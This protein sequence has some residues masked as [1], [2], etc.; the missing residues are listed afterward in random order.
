VIDFRYHV[1]SIVAI[2]LA[3]ATGIALGAGPLGKEFDQQLANQARQDREA[4]E[5]LRDQLDQTNQVMEF[6]GDFAQDLAPQLT[7]N[8]LANRTVAVFVLPGADEDTV[9]GVTSRIEGAGATIT[10]T[11]EIQDSLMDPAERQTA[12]GIATEV[13][14]GVQGLPDTEGAQ[15]YQLVGYSLARGYLATSEEG[16]PVDQVAASIDGAFGD[17][18]AGYLN[19][20]GDL[21]Q[22]A[23]LA[24]V[25]AGP[26]SEDPQVG[27]GELLAIMVQA[28]DTLSGG[29]VVA[30]PIAAAGDDGYITAV[31]DSTASDTV[32]TVDVAD[33]PA[34]QIVTVLALDQQAEGSVGQYGAADS[35]DDAMPETEK[36]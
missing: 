23:N 31:R 5:D 11:I 12:E 16:A 19:L 25:I 34:G 6:E 14:K 22:R 10:A 9:D 30:G 20:D 29:V 4:K 18:G 35:A 27:Q 32:S 3:L 33:R 13:L 1:I 2:F 28:M 26:P 8:R 21:T 17:G 36:Q 7:N 15:S 24:V